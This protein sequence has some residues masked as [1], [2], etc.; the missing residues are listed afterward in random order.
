MQTF[1]LRAKTNKDGIAHL[2]IPTHLIDRDVEIVVVLNAIEN[3]PVDEMG[4]PIG[5]FD[6]TY[7]S[8]A[9]EPLVRD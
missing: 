3:K 2:E 7:G 9:D 4:Y 8:F 1:T 6:E 5:Y